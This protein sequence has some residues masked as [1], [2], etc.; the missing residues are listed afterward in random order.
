MLYYTHSRYYIIVV[1]VKI[2][3]CRISL[4][5]VI[6]VSDFGLAVNLGTKH[7][8]RQDKNT[9]IKLPLRWSA[10]ESISDFLF[11]E[12]SDVVSQTCTLIL[13]IIIILT[14]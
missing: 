2:F 1:H 3:F 12:K 7:Y 8:F 6:K 5:F 10:P 4:N 11:S 9:M 13:I 14:I